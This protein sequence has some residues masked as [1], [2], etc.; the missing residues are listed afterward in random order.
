[1]HRLCLSLDCWPSLMTSRCHRTHWF[2]RY[3]RGCFLDCFEFWLN[4]A[5]RYYNT[6]AP[7]SFLTVA[8]R[9]LSCFFHSCPLY[10]RGLAFII[11]GC[12][13]LDMVL[14]SAIEMPR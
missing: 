11:L 6:V 4:S 13:A 1:M 9:G 10:F 14:G 8:S 12:P 5:L 7:I 2:Y 3:E